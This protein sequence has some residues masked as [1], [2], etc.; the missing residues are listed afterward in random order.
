MNV[1]RDKINFKYQEMINILKDELNGLM[2]DYYTL[3]G[4]IMFH[5]AEIEFSEL[6]YPNSAVGNLSRAEIEKL[7]TEQN[8]ILDRMTDIEKEIKEKELEKLC[9]V[10]IYT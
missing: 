8:A 9:V 6:Y 4:K 2:A 1:T 3:N 7:K 10:G 5:S